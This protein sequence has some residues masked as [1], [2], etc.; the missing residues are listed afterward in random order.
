MM[1][2]ADSEI[3]HVPQ[4]VGGTRGAEALTDACGDASNECQAA[5]IGLHLAAS[6]S[7]YV[8]NVWNWV[9]DHITEGFSGGSSIA[10]KG[11][12]LVEATA[13]TWLHALGTEH[14]W[15]YQLNLR[16]AR[17][18]LVSLLQSETNY[19]QGDNAEQTV[20]APWTADAAGWGDPDYAWCGGGDKRCRMG[21]SNYIQGGADIYHYGSA[22]WAFFSGPGYQ[23]CGT[24]QCQGEFMTYVLDLAQSFSA[25]RS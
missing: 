11:G 9:A 8:E 6:S 4:T 19:E 7:V 12:T 15:L 14:Y 10:A 2:N 21:L 25:E 23:S 18:V 22:S 5:F 17:N 13:G 16:Q 1:S 20:P 24:F 3:F